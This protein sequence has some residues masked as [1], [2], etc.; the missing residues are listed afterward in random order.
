MPDS[1]GS[2]FVWA[3]LPKGYEN[4]VE[5]CFELLERTG[6]LC[7]PGSAFGTLGEGHVRFALVQPPEVMAEIVEAVKQSGIVE[8]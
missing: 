6:L 4:S 7:T 5:F 1:Q 2:M 3:P 8:N